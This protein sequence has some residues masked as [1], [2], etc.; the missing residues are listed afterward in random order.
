MSNTL[1]PNSNEKE[2]LKKSEK[3]AQP[4]QDAH[5][6]NVDESVQLPVKHNDNEPEHKEI[7]SMSSQDNDN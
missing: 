5:L 2:I 6:E 7:G 3:Q 1:E 4:L